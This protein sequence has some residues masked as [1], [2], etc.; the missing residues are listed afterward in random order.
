[1]GGIYY[2]QD[3]THKEN[4]TLRSN[5]SHEEGWTEEDHKDLGVILYISRSQRSDELRT[6]LLNSFLDDVLFIERIVITRDRIY[7]KYQYIDGKDKLVF[8]SN[9]SSM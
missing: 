3:Q 8:E 2:F 6:L 4:Y 1:M 5:Y 7:Q 9:L